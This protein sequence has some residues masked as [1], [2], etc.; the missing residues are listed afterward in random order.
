MVSSRN[1]NILAVATV[2]LLVA[3]GFS[4]PA[5][6][7]A[8]GAAVHAAQPGAIM[9]AQSSTPNGADANKAAN[10]DPIV[11][12]GPVGTPS[13][14]PHI[15]CGAQGVS[16]ASTAS[17]MLSSATTF[18]EQGIHSAGWEPQIKYDG[19][20]LKPGTTA[21]GGGK[22]CLF[23]YRDVSG[24]A[25]PLP[26]GLK[27]VLRPGTYNGKVVNL[28]DELIFKCGPGSTTDLAQPPSQCPSGNPALSTSARFPQCWDGVN[29]DTVRPDGSPATNPSTGAVYP[30]D[31]LSHMQ[32]GPC[33]S[34]HP[35][36]IIRVEQFFR[37]WYGT[38]VHDIEK[39]TFGGHHWSTF[40]TDYVAAWQPNTMT[41]FMNR[42]ITP[43]VAC[44]TNINLVN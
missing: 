32:Y 12:P 34:T 37:H 43:N 35:T 36:E 28:G 9:S 44:A 22:H 13:E 15:F 27:M 26:F 14:H 5:T 11:S 10:V 18:V 1:R 41:D 33:D 8:P 19:V 17:S 23:Y 29:L 24:N 20:P 30:N 39:L 6:V 31:H 16:S 38:T 7:E 3:I 2:L 25:G 4:A 42:C 21:T 40:H